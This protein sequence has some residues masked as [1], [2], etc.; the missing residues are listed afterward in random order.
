M[1]ISC[2]SNERELCALVRMITG[3]CDSHLRVLSLA[4][5]H[6]II[7]MKMYQLMVEHTAEEENLDWTKI[8]P[9]V[10][11]LKSPKGDWL[12]IKYR[13]SSIMKWFC[14]IGSVAELDDDFG[15]VRSKWK[16]E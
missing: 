15:L 3:Q 14:W 1:L 13:K 11:L 9:S 2:T 8:E 6:D 5:N 12:Q 4:D 10:S 7:S 16:H